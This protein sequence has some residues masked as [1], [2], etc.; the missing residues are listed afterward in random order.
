[1]VQD[2]AGGNID[3]DESEFIYKRLLRLNNNETFVPIV[4]KLVDRLPNDLVY[5]IL[6]NKGDMPDTS[7]PKPLCFEELISSEAST[8]SWPKLDAEKE[9]LFGKG[10][11]TGSQTARARFRDLLFLA[12]L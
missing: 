6:C 10:S 4:E 11:L 8:I 1:M 9:D 3:E 2:D 12:S 5:V 7:L